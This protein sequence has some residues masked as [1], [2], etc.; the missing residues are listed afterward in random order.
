MN[1]KGSILVVDDEENITE[2][3]NGIL[4]DEGYEVDITQSGDKA[5]E[6]LKE[7]AFDLVLLDIWLPGRKDGLQTLREIRK[8]KMDVDV[9]MI[10]GHGS[11]DTAVRATKLG[12][13]NFIEKPL[14]LDTVLETIHSVLKQKRSGK[15]SKNAVIGKK[16]EYRYVAKSAAMREVLKQA[17]KASKTFD[18]VLIIGEDGTG[19]Q[20]T[21]SY[22]H[23][24]SKLQD[25]P[26]ITV[27]S[28]DL[29][30]SA[31]EKLFGPLNE[32]LSAKNSKFSKITGTVF[33]ANP[34]LFD[35]KIQKRIAALIKL[36][37]G[38]RKKT[39][40][41]I[42]S[43][44]TSANRKIKNMDASLKVF[45]KKHELRLPALREREEDISELIIYFVGHASEDFGKPDVDVS[46]KAMDRMI[47]YPWP[48]NVKEL[49]SV[50]ENTLMSCPAHLIEQSD[51]AF[52]YSLKKKSNSSTERFLTKR[53]NTTKKRMKKKGRTY[54][55]KT[56]GQSVV[57]TGLGLHSG[58]KTGLI[59]SPLPPRSGIIFGDISSGRQVAAL[60]DHV[61]TTGYATSIKF[62]GTSVKT[63][64]H[65][66]ATLHIYGITNAL[67]KVNDEVPIMD[68]S[69][70]AFC[71][72]IEHAG[73]VEQDD[74]IEPI[75]ITAPITIGEGDNRTKSLT[76]EPS[77]KLE[78]HYHM[79]YPQ[80]VG[81]M[82]A[83]FKMN[84]L[85]FFKT[86]IA[87][88]R[89]FGFVSDIKNFEEAGLAE[90]GKLTNVILVDDEKI[91]NT[92]LRFE[93]EFARH[94]ILDI[95][96][97]MYLLGRP[98]IGKISARLTGHTE[99]IAMLK[100]IRETL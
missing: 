22:I 53:E 29:T 91:V 90:G 96:G 78:I 57:L 33:M 54:L 44:Q 43:L 12:A 92:T 98:L 8:R 20:Y 47:S 19:K 100:K 55:Q 80:P 3:L 63:I 59:I 95:L 30:T 24:N 69:A 45:F 81:K 58:T 51:I 87:P 73:V 61:D 71:K 40:R 52:D 32:D 31:F 16:G 9:I 14:S 7:K 23:Q 48:G 97:D 99:N 79:D 84:G 77:D 41:F 37:N 11:I 65:I 93:D 60:V 26:F 75:I 5:L 38:K 2:S 10:S 13:H 70:A 68:G 64:E 74:E 27:D 21:A 6:I 36:Q 94:K 34:N 4:T 18:P 17:T 25:E 85:E 72:L 89:T 66:M 49:Q 88:A 42:A 1:K 46:E 28:I 35:T 62:G 82:D 56:I 67:L 76:I 50:I 15:K 83:V 86:E 39:V